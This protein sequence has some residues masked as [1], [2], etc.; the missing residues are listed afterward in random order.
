MRLFEKE[1]S[2]ISRID[3]F[4]W[5]PD[6]IPRVLSIF[7]D[8]KKDI[9]GNFE[10]KIQEEIREK[11]TDPIFKKDDA[12]DWVFSYPFFSQ[13]NLP[14][15]PEGMTIEEKLEKFKG[16]HSSY[17]SVSKC[18]N[19]ASSRFP[20]VFDKINTIEQEELILPLIGLIQSSP[21]ALADLILGTWEPFTL[22]HGLFDKKGEKFTNPLFLHL[23]SIA[24]WD[25]TGTLKIPGNKDVQ[26][27][28]LREFSSP[29]T[30]AD[31]SSR[32][33]ALLKISLTRGY[34]IYYDIGYATQ[35]RIYRPSLFPS[36]EEKTPPPN[37]FWVKIRVRQ[38]DSFFLRKSKVKNVTLLLNLLKARSQISNHIRGKLSNRMQN[39]LLRYENTEPSDAFTAFLIEEI[40]RALLREDFYNLKAFSDINLSKNTKESIQGYFN[41]LSWDDRITGSH[42]QIL[43]MR[44]R[45]LLDDAFPDAIF[46]FGEKYNS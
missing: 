35:D 32:E 45:Y 11:E 37:K 1:V 34:D 25:L 17:D 8:G 30:N 5:A 46:R 13:V 3:I 2:V 14:V 10:K 16:L 38:A 44:N 6:E 42:Y 40:N 7:D 22:S 27:F 20:D 15:F 18:F 31:E 43:V 28:E 4:D 41:I 26:S 33:D 29:P 23:V 19:Q 36:I 12:S 9:E 21:A 24:I 39:L